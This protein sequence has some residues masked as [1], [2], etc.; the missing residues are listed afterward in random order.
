MNRKQSLLPTSSLAV[1]FSIIAIGACLPAGAATIWNGPNIGW[2]KSVATPSDPIL[3]GVVV[4]TRGLNE[5]MYNTVS[6]TGPTV[7]SPADTEWGFGT[8]A[9]F[10]TLTYKTMDAWRATQSF[11]FQALFLNKQMVMHIKSQDIY[12]SIMFTNWGRFGS[13]TVGYIRSTAAGGGNPPTVTLTNPV[14]GAVFAAPASI[15]LKASASVSGGTVTNVEYFAGTTSLGHAT[16]SPFAVT[17]NLPN[18]GSYALKAVATASGLSATSSVV[19]ITVV[20]PTP[21]TLTPPTFVGGQF[22]FSY[23][24]DPGL[25]YVVQSSSNLVDWVSVVTNVAAGTSVPFSTGLATD[26][27]F[28][29]VGQ[30]PNP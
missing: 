5:V 28:Y 15:N 22:S 2:A 18:P 27:A 4:L 17:G 13:G 23:S 19:N 26:P 6:E 25:R 1:G 24:A 11:D 20:S 3:P 29:R 12:M 9:N 7:G 14:S 8:L 10:S 16:T 21:V 30:L